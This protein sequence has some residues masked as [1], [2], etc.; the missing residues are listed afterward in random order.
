MTFASIEAEKLEC[1]YCKVSLVD[2]ATNSVGFVTCPDCQRTYLKLPQAPNVD[3]SLTL[4][5]SR[6]KILDLFVDPSINENAL[7]ELKANAKALEEDIVK[8]TSNVKIK[9]EDIVRLKSNVRVQEEDIE[10]LKSNVKIK[11]EDIATL[12]SNQEAIIKESNNER[13]ILVENLSDTQ[14]ALE[15]IS[16]LN[17]ELKTSLNEANFELR[18][19]HGV[20]SEKNQLMIKLKNELDEVTEKLHQKEDLY[21]T[22]EKENGFKTS[23]LAN[24]NNDLIELKNLS[25]TYEQKIV[26]LFLELKNEKNRLA[27]LNLSLEVIPDLEMELEKTK[28]EVLELQKI[29]VAKEQESLHEMNSDQIALLNDEI[30]AL[31][32]DVKD[33]ANTISELQSKLNS[34]NDV[35]RNKESEIYSLHHQTQEVVKATPPTENL[36]QATLFGN[37]DSE[38]VIK[39]R[40]RVRRFEQ[41]EQKLEHV[42]T[43]LEISRDELSK[44][45]KEIVELNNLL[46]KA[47][48]EN[49]KSQVEVQPVQSEKLVN[50][51]RD[52]EKREDDLMEFSYELNSKIDRFLKQFE[53]FKNL[54]FDVA[55]I[56][57]DSN[58]RV[59]SPLFSKGTLLPIGE[60]ELK[61]VVTYKTNINKGLVYFKHE[62]DRNL[63]LNSLKIDF[64]SNSLFFLNADEFNALVDSE[65]EVEIREEYSLNS[66][67]ELSVAFYR[68]NGFKR[69][70]AK[71]GKLLTASVQSV[72]KFV[73]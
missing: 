9:E 58:G 26:E 42:E 22:L 64:S 3:K 66:A 5:S 38:E 18:R 25:N 55:V 15:E 28:G 13:Q 46:E 48:Y 36:E 45:Q 34:Q 4:S 70:D 59:V 21:D 71:V 11:E 53:S 39:L 6:K 2:Q 40:D 10:K 62:D 20:I 72:E 33:Y 68:N 73:V 12:K 1:K 24:A 32:N 69:F 27:E 8:L 67:G 41:T 35:I 65:V 51:A 23:S 37:Y 19:V 60:M 31:K 44:A 29:I 63:V 30:N 47:F 54:T 57:E 7:S 14:E 61:K 52:I 49:Q 43:E 50:V 16:I 56:R 17:Q